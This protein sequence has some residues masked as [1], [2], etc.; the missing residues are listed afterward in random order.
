MYYL[1]VGLLI[2]M[3]PAYSN[4]DKDIVKQIDQFNQPE[5]TPKECQHCLYFFGS[6][7]QTESTPD[8]DTSLL[9]K[10]AADLCGPAKDSPQYKYT[11]MTRRYYT[12][13]RKTDAA[14]S[15]NKTVRQ[16]IR[17]NMERKRAALKDF[18]DKLRDP[19]SNLT[20]QEWDQAA[21]AFLEDFIEQVPTHNSLQ[22]RI[23]QSTPIPLNPLKEQSIRSYLSN[24]NKGQHHACQEE[25]KQWV[26]KELQLMYDLL[27][28]NNIYEYS[29]DHQSNFCQ[30][31]YIADVQFAQQA[32]LYREDLD[33]IKDKFLNTVFVGYSDTSRQSYRDYISTIRFNLPPRSEQEE[34]IAQRLLQHIK[35]NSLAPPESNGKIAFGEFIKRNKDMYKPICPLPVVLGSDVFAP[36][37]STLNISLFSCTFHEHGKQ[38]LAHE[39]GHAMSHWFNKNKPHD[40]PDNPSMISYE[41]YMKLR[42][43]ANRRRTINNAPNSVKYKLFHHNNDQWRTE[44]DVADLI[45][46][47]V[48]QDDPILNNCSR[49]ITSHNDLK[50]TSL[51][52]LHPTS[53]SKKADTHSTNFL[54]VLMEAIHKRIELPP[55]CQQVV[56]IYSDRINFEPCF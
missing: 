11:V 10:C 4:Q 51:K 52:V 42:A 16:M 41:E 20:A 32:K 55:S 54:R 19:T 49:L 37:T 35:D 43:C 44:E 6:D 47:K 9:Q 31:T 27:K 45:A 24:K 33:P 15:F 46:Y 29:I 36:H 12:E 5:S 1:L 25:C 17:T 7:S 34:E 56:D 38:T 14:R 30:D 13:G 48:F 53:K 50:Y 2:F 18:E 39:L 23:K 22:Y 28:Q 26:K 21:E 3:I 40:Q 8:Q